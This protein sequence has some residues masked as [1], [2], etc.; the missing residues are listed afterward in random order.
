MNSLRR[1]AL[2]LAILAALALASSGCG[3]KATTAKKPTSGP[4]VKAT[5]TIYA[6]VP[7]GQVGPFSEVDKLFRKAYPGVD[8]NWIPENMVTIVSKVLDG[9][10]HPDAVL[11]M[12]DLE[13]DKIEKAGLMVEGTRAEY[14]ENG[15][16]LTVPAGNPGGVETLADLAKPA[17]KIISIPKPEDNSVG[18]HAIEALKAAGL[19]DK[20]QRKVVFPQFAADAKEVV[21]KKQAQASIGYYPC[22]SE[23]HIKNAPPAQPKGEKMVGLI[24]PQDYQPFSCEACVIKGCKNPEGGRTL[25]EFLKRPEVT[26][27]FRDWNFLREEAPPTPAQKPAAG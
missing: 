11:S 23:V 13:I 10:E 21:Q 7:C 27:L 8:L 20:V 25:I 12:G 14:A 6:M 5:E 15:L 24:P 22:V 16:A 1:W 26:K 17:V 9:K 3:Q 4:G 2:A 18:K 19:W